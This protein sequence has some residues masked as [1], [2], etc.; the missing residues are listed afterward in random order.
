MKAF[1]LNL[2]TSTE[3]REYMNGILKDVTV[4]HPIFIDAIDGRKL[5]ENERDYLFDEERFKREYDR[6]I[7]PGEIGCTLSHQKC[8]RELLHSDD[9]SLIIFED[10]I[11]VNSEITALLPKVEKWLSVDEPRVMLLSGWFWHKKPQQFFEEYKIA[12]IIDGF[13]THAYA[14]NKSA[15][16]LMLDTKPWYL[17]DAWEMFRNRGIKIMGLKPH[18]FDQDWSGVFT[19][20][21]NDEAIN[22]NHKLSVK[23]LQEKIRSLRNKTLQIFGRFEHPQSIPTI[24]I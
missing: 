13:L 5:P 1:I 14:L 24:K 20:T 7:R 6:S 3:R 21:V 12:E 19:T 15:A 8:Y 17:A 22:K 9:N 18:P 23:L 4:V 10:D 11:I 2:R 16:R